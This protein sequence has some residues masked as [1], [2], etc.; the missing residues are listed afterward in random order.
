[1]ITTVRK[2]AR[3]SAY[4]LIIYIYIPPKGIKGTLYTMFSIKVLE[5]HSR[6][7]SDIDSCQTNMKWKLNVA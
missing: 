5:Q 3:F 6:F 4:N 1:M 2:Q 7:S